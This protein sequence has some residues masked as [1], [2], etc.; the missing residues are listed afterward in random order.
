MSKTKLD[1]DLWLLN[2]SR[3]KPR[4]VSPPVLEVIEAGLRFG[5]FSNG[6]FDITIGGLTD[7]WD[8]SPGAEVPH[9]VMVEMWRETVD[10]RKVIIDGSSV[11][12]EYLTFIDLGGIAKG[13][14]A[15]RMAEIIINGGAAGVIIDLGGD[16]AIAGK[17]PD[18]EPWRLGIRKPFSE[19]GELFGIVETR[20][21]A[22]VTSGV[23][24]RYF[25]DTDTNIRY[26]HI[27]DPATGMPAITDI[28]S[29]TVLADSAMT[30]DA[31]STIAL[32]AGSKKAVELLPTAEGF[33][34]A[35]LLLENGEIIE[36]GEV[37]FTAA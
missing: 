13:Y 26:H 7:L 24:E 4:D 8:F 28:I 19:H 37:D 31:L 10:Y 3:H 2:R 14:I 25:T 18:G 33:I 32:L 34:G 22:V 27:L 35:V 17:K 30:G 23:Y 9:P 21:C 12:T 29:A 36:I 20:G 1:G 15:D 5:E 6:L 11:Q 16:V